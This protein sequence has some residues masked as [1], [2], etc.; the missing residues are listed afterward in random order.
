MLFFVTAWVSPIMA[1]VFE[2]QEMKISIEAKNLA[3]RDVFSQIEKKSGYAIVYEKGIIDPG[4]KVN[5][6]AKDESVDEVLN[7]VLAQTGN[8]YAFVNNQI[9]LTKAS[10]TN[11]TSQQQSK[12]TISGEIVDEMDLGLPGVSVIVKGTTTG[13][14]TDVDGNFQISISDPKAILIISY[15]GY[16]SQEISV[17]N[18]TSF[19]IKLVPENQ[20]LDEIVVIGYG[21]VKKRDLIGSVSSVKSSDIVQTPTSNAIEAIQGKVA[22]V[23][24]TRQSGKA[25]S[26]VD[27]LIRGTK[28]ISGNVKPL[29]VIDGVQGGDFSDINPGDIESIE[30][31]KDATSTAIY[32]SQG[33]NGVVIISTKRGKEGRAKISYDGYF[34][35]NGYFDYPDMRMGDSYTQLR[36]EAYRTVGEWNSPADDYAIFS[37]EEWNAVQNNQWVDWVDLATKNGLQQSH[38][39]SFSSATDKTRSFISLSYFNEKGIFEN[40]D[41]TRYTLRTNIDQDLAKWLT[42]GVSSQLTYSEIDNRT[43]SVLTAAASSVPLGVPYDEE[44]NVNKFP[45]PGDQNTISPLADDAPNTAVN[46]MIR[47]NVNSTGYLEFKPNKNWNFRS[48]VGVTLNFSRQGIYN[49]NYSREN[50]LAKKKTASVENKNK[51]FFIWDNILNYTKTIADHSITATAITSWTSD[52][53]ETD[54]AYGENQSLDSYLY[55][56]LEAT[57]P[58]TRIIKSPYTKHTTMAYAGRLNYSFKG[59]YLVTATGRWDGDSRLAAGNKWDFFPSIAGA[60]RI[61][62][63]AFMDGLKSLSDMKI[64]ASY[65]TTGNS[66]IDIY[67]TQSGVSPYSTLGFNDTAAPGYM[68]NTTIGNSD[69]TWEKSATT[70]IGLDLGFINNR[71]SANIDLYS[72]KTQDMLLLRTLP[73]STGG[74]GSLSV[75]QN[76][77]K[78]SNKGIEITLNSVNIEKKD[79]RWTSTLTFTSNREKITE[80]VDGKDIIS[81]KNPE[82]ESYL[83]GHAI[84]SFY[85]FKKL[86]IWQLGEEAEMA[87]YAEGASPQTFKPGYIKVEDVDGDYFID[88]AKDRQYLGSAVPDWV[89][90]FNNTVY[91]KGFDFSIYLFARWGQMINHELLGRYDPAGKNNSA[92]YFNYWT[93]E[94]PT[95]DFPR[96]EKDAKLY[97]YTGYQAINFTEGSFFKIKNIS[98]GYTLPKKVLESWKISNLR[99]YTTASNLFTYSPNHLIKD[100]DPERGG[101]DTSPLTKQIIFGANFSF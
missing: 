20:G 94:N 18:K 51:R 8:S 7:K 66:G 74:N 82:T 101:K 45:I 62:D 91:F 4:K 89:A 60:W 93:P 96:P 78:T 38:A 1:S 76:V 55:H 41:M 29:F 22:G 27:I 77:G 13:T 65:G 15:I 88:Q 3:V 12:I 31:L 40:D 24:I 85:S 81:A 63:E 57:D 2:L 16:Q 25:G 69:L 83:L 98:L 42:V 34:G 100:Y 92:A 95:N 80:L 17:G 44:G 52:I 73:G 47:A 64:R 70:N 84:K 28:T 54:Y 49:S 11:T 46:N 48:N 14:A 9:V 86:G 79:F 59:K 97:N 36:R 71:I 87:K 37:S 30:V 53:N 99:I 50:Y 39:V 67:G 61:G 35:L 90:G 33:A 32:G 43:E 58:S 23:D 56:N 6:V 26:D 75:Y 10:P 5:V 68:F 21:T 72:I 19:R